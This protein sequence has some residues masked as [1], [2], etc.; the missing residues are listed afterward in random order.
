MTASAIK[1]A[2]GAIIGVSEIAR[3]ITEQRR[4]QEQQNLLLRE[5]SH[6]VKNLFAVASGR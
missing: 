4:A 5:M 6:R 1:N 2:E 3:D